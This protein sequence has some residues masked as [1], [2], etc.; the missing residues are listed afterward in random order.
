MRVGPQF[1]AV[2]PDYDPGKVDLS[3]VKC[4]EGAGYSVREPRTQPVVSL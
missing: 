4:D 3:F 1:Q 2:V